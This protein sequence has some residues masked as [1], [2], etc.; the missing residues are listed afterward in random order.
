[1]GGGGGGRTL[2]AAL[3]LG[4]INVSISLNVNYDTVLTI[5]NIISPERRN[6]LV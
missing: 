3:H 2:R 6:V 1:V 4:I 5:Q